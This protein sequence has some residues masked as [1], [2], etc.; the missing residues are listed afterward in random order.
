MPVLGNVLLEVSGTDHL[1]LAATDLLKAFRL[2]RL[3]VAM[4]ASGG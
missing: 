3:A 2:R 1:R 4:T